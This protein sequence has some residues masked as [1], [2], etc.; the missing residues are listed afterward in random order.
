MLW[1]SS[2]WNSTPQQPP[3]PSTSPPPHL[4]KQ[5]PPPQ[6]QASESFPGGS[7]ANRPQKCAGCLT[8]NANPKYD[9]CQTCFMIWDRLYRRKYCARCGSDDIT[10][11]RDLC[12]ECYD[13]WKNGQFHLRN[14]EEIIKFNSLEEELNDLIG[15]YHSKPPG[16]ED[17]HETDNSLLWR[18]VKDISKFGPDECCSICLEKLSGDGDDDDDDDDNDDDDDEPMKVVRLK[19]CN[20]CFHEECIKHCLKEGPSLKCPNCGSIE[21]KFIGN[22]PEGWMAISLDKDTDL[23]GFP[24]GSGFIGVMYY[25]PTGVQK[26]NHPNP[27]AKYDRTIRS[28]YF[29][30]TEEGRKVVRLIRVAFLRKLVFSVGRSVTNG[31]DNQVI[32]NGIHHKT[33]VSGGAERHG[34]PDPSYLERVQDE[35]SAFSITESKLIEQTKEK[36]E[37]NDDGD[38]NNEEEDENNTN[39]DTNDDNDNDDEIENSQVS[40]SAS[41]FT[42]A[43]NFVVTN[44][45]FKPSSYSDRAYLPTDK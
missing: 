40:A 10:H 23:E 5:H 34:Y 18:E 31:K 32:W 15:I 16:D 33:H 24:Q 45:L 14:Y 17:E 4:V 20:H 1:L 41:I 35:L 27:G 43:Y 13:K 19:K 22:Q 38:D 3:P 36:E 6:A 44:V 30:N 21:G 42:K 29:P 25:V 28:C 11:P 2:L 8:N 7:N 9:L 12:G 26:E 39:T 37:E